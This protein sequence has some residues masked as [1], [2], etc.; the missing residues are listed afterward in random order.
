M[1]YV[2][3]MPDAWHACLVAIAVPQNQTV[4]AVA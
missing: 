1:N 4:N 3:M 2:M